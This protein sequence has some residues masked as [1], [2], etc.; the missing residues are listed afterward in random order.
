MYP[1]KGGNMARYGRDFDRDRFGYSGRGGMENNYDTDF[2]SGG[3]G[4][5][6]GGYG[7][8]SGGRSSGG[9]GGMNR[10]GMNQGGYGGG[11]NQGGGYGGSQGGYGGSSFG[12]GGNYGGA[13]YGGGSY[14]GGRGG[15][16]TGFGSFGGGYQGGGYNTG[17]GYSG[18]YGGYTDY[19]DEQ[20]G[21]YGQGGWG[22]TGG[23]QQGQWNQQNQGSQVRASEIMTENPETV[24][25][26]VSLAE[27]AKKMRDLDVGIIPVVESAE[28]RRLKGVITDR[29]ITIRAVAEGK[30]VSKTKVSECMTTDVETCNKNDTVQDVL[31]AMQR[32]QVRRVPITDREGRLVGIIAQADVAVDYAS[33]RSG[34]DSDIAEAVER[35]SEPAQ[36]ERN[37]GRG[38]Q[39]QGRQQ[40]RNQSGGG[41]QTAGMQAGGRT[42][43]QNQGT[44]TQQNQGS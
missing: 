2:R 23:R 37:R 10:G 24:T 44:Q 40:S 43:Q 33:G 36:P 9:Y 11:M 17:A 27:A 19:L 30:D 31:N 29:D 39:G 4:Q 16:D 3:I 42:G 12:G 21:G 38:A 1:K 26:D 22:Q 25:G 13:G 20:Q 8:M 18:G 14:G 5:N 28:S 41:T 32:E 7:G 6:R 15:Y 34:R 35:I